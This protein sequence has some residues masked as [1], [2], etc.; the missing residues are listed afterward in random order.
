MVWPF[1]QAT[2]GR[3]AD[4]AGA[5]EARAEL[6]DGLDALPDPTAAKDVAMA[7]GRM[8]PRR[9]AKLTPQQQPQQ[10]DREKMLSGAAH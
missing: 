4:P 8:T 7:E 6:A 1:V 2:Y 9:M 10:P 3:G 5:A